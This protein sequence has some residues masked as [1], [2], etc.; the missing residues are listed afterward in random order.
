MFSTFDKTLVSK[1]LLIESKY[2][3]CSTLNALSHEILIDFFA[4]NAVEK[5]RAQEKT[6]C[7]LAAHC[8]PGAL[9]GARRTY[10]KIF[11]ST[12]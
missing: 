9:W 8:G 2:A 7:R 12:I 3:F 5:I 10:A 4:R 1:A 6:F 11:F